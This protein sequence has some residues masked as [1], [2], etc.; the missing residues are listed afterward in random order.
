MGI[1]KTNGDSEKS[2]VARPTSESLESASLRYQLSRNPPKSIKKKKVYTEEDMAEWEEETQ[3]TFCND[4]CQGTRPKTEFST[5]QLKNLAKYRKCKKCVLL[6]ILP[7]HPDGLL[8]EYY[9][10]DLHFPSRVTWCVR[11]L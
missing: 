4:V 7:V 11:T 5:T 10:I 3:E 1:T 6:S 2:N 9:F 8:C